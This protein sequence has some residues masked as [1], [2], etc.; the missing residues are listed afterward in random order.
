M[1][2]KKTILNIFNNYESVEEYGRKIWKIIHTKAIKADTKSKQSEFIDMM[3][4]ICKNFKCDKCKIHCSNYLSTN[5]PERYLNTTVN[6]NG[7]KKNLGLFV[8]SWKFH[9]SVNTRKGYPNISLQ[10]AYNM[11]S[12]NSGMVHLN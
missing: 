5:P 2:S 8:W 10:T 12:G 6:V 9:N 1:S 7:V 3:H 11:Y 4:F